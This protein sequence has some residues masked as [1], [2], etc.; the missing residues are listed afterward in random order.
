MFV[1]CAR[2]SRVLRS[3][4]TM[5][6]TRFLD[7]AVNDK[8]KLRVSS[9]AAKTVRDLSSAPLS[10]KLAGANSAVPSSWDTEGVCVVRCATVRSLA[11]C[12]A[13][14]D[15]KKLSHPWPRRRSF[16]L[17]MKAVVFHRPGHV[18]V[19]QVPDPKIE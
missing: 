11:V 8:R 13:R 6:A 12:A 7:F 18:E 2:C 16:L 10:H 4:F 15:K 14:D 9:R 3:S 1:I 5:N 17:H 19:N